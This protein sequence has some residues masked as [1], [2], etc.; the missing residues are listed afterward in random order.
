MFPC[1]SPR[2]TIT[3]LF[4]HCPVI[5]GPGNT[6]YI[7]IDY[8][9]YKQ[10]QHLDS[11]EEIVRMEPCGPWMEKEGPEYW[12]DLK[13]RLKNRVFGLCSDTTTEMEEVSDPR[14]V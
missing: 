6:Q 7:S 8:V 14:L 1:S 2:L 4:P 11:N 13:L 12:E 10:F 3:T 9:D 5:F